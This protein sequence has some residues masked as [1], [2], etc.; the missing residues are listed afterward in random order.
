MRSL[1]L[2]SVLLQFTNWPF[3]FRGHWRYK[4]NLQPPE[5]TGPQAYQKTD[6]GQ[7]KTEGERLNRSEGRNGHACRLEQ[8]N[9]NVG[10]SLEGSGLVPVPGL[11]KPN[12]F[13]YT[14]KYKVL[15]VMTP[16]YIQSCG[17][18][19]GSSLSGHA[20][21]MVHL[22]RGVGFHVN[23]TVVHRVHFYNHK[24]TLKWRAL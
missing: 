20:R 11:E 5:V 24:A 23:F 8:I 15:A 3:V 7:A 6:W 16:G 4:A 9:S 18:L 19:Y 17:L 12:K 13:I 1:R 14:C 22:F 10:M 2:F 21:K